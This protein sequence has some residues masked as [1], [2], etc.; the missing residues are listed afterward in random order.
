MLHVQ[1]LLVIQTIL[2][3]CCDQRIVIIL[4]SILR[5]QFPRR[6][7]WIGRVNQLTRNM[8]MFL[9]CSRG[10]HCVYRRQVHTRWWKTCHPDG[11]CCSLQNCPAPLMCWS[12][13]LGTAHTRADHTHW[14]QLTHVL[15][16]RVGTAHTCV[17]HTQWTQLTHVLSRTQWAQLTHVLSHTQ[18][19]QLTRVLSH[20]QWAQFT[21]VLSHTQWIRDTVPY[22]CW[23]THSGSETQLPTRAESHIV[24]TAP[25]TCWSHT[26]DTAHTCAESHTG[27]HFSVKWAKLVT[28]RQDQF[29]SLE[30]R[31][32]AIAEGN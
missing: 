8:K 17:S 23:I 26:V 11:G 22:A 16:H 29:S 27:S 9:M 14:G 32:S 12:H 6:I 1:I 21:R 2:R 5:K 18:W 20:T 7:K 13:T 30:Y 19:A 31:V 15:G 3:E 4:R 10:Q 28:F 24:G 25:H